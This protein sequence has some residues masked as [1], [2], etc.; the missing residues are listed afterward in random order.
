V[1]YFLC[2]CNINVK[3]NKKELNIISQELIFMKIMTMEVFLDVC[4]LQKE[5]AGRKSTF[6]RSHSRV[7]K[8]CKSGNGYCR[9]FNTEYGVRG[10]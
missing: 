10:H 3:I 6:S 9:V 7:K 1:R 5:C 4:Q 8:S 2:I